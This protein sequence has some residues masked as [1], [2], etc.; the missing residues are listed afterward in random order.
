M[1]VDSGILR[2]MVGTQPPMKV[3]QNLSRKVGFVLLVFG[4]LTWQCTNPMLSEN[5]WDK[6]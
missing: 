6:T 3:S 2:S 4:N 1:D 5:T